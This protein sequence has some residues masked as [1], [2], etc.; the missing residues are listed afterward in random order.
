MPVHQLTSIVETRADLPAFLIELV[1]MITQ[2]SDP[3]FPPLPAIL[4][5]AAGSSNRMRGSDKLLEKIEGTAQIAR[6]LSFAIK[7][8]CPVWITLPP[9]RPDRI[10]AIAGYGGERIVVRDANNGMAASI[11]AGVAAIPEGMAVLILL[12]DLPEITEI[13][14]KQV[15]TAYRGSP[16]LIVRATS[17]DGRPG[18]PVLIPAS[19]RSKLGTLSGDRGA[20][21]ILHANPGKTLSIALPD[22]HAI[23]DLDTPEDWDLWRAR[24]RIP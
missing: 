16:D 18:H 12:A 19:L 10:A 7:T 1:A 22:E 2:Q 17:A 20:Q 8:G 3:D 13:D 11:R 5:L 9:D 23:T 6:I 4:I 24:K 21:S 15:I 14:L